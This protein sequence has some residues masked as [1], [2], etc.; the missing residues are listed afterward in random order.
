MEFEFSIKDIDVI[1]HSIDADKSFSF[2][3]RKNVQYSLSFSYEINL[4]ESTLKIKT[5]TSFRWFKNENSP[6]SLYSI[7]VQS[8]FFIK[9]LHTYLDEKKG[10]TNSVLK[11]LLNMSFSHTRGIQSIHIKGTPIDHVYI[12]SSEIDPEKFNIT[13]GDD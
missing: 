9:E 2:A 5:L 3:D 13:L 8:T 11:P 7:E 4:P 10:V 6:I 1:S 12:P